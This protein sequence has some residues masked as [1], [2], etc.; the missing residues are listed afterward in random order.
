M[1]EGQGGAS[2]TDVR[3]RDGYRQSVFRS[4]VFPYLDKPN[5]T[6]LTGALVTRVTFDH[7]L[8]TGV[9]FAHDGKMQRVAAGSEVVLSLG[10]IHTPKVLMQ[11]GIGNHAELQ[12]LGIPVLQHLPGVGQNLQDQ[13]GFSCVWEYQVPLPP[14]NNGGEATYFWKSGRGPDAPDLQACQAEFPLASPGT[15]ARFDLPEFGWGWG[16]RVVRP[17]SRGHICP[18]GPDPTD[19]CR[20]RQTCCLTPMT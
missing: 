15:A 19:Q 4:Y 7:N 17:K 9:E 13:P 1:M 6:V 12:R 18:T 5:L 20:S 14:R 3:A 11:S 2:I 16:A 10:A 8:A